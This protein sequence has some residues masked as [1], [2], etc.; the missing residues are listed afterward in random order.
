[1]SRYTN[2]KM[3]EINADEFWYTKVMP[4][5][6]THRIKHGR[7]TSNIGI[8]VVYKNPLMPGF[9]VLDM[10]MYSQK[11][12]KGKRFYHRNSLGEVVLPRMYRY[13]IDEQTFKQFFCTETLGKN[14]NDIIKKAIKIA[15]GIKMFDYVN[16]DLDKAPTRND[17]AKIA[18]EMM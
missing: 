4:A 17:V 15:K 1:M 14:Y 18:K 12:R 11:Q 2:E 3:M 8:P 13:T 9:Y 5:I 16:G 6:H 10:Y 7:K